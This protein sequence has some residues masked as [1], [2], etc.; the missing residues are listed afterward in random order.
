ME[1]MLHKMPPPLPPSQ[2]SCVRG[3]HLQ[4]QQQQQR[5]AAAELLYS[6]E[7]LSARE[8]N[9][10]K[11]K[12]KALSRVDSLRSHDSFGP[13][14]SLRSPVARSRSSHLGEQSSVT[15]GT[16]AGE[17][18][19]AGGAGEPASEGAAAAAGAGVGWGGGREAAIGS[20]DAEEEWKA[21]QAGAWPLQRVCDQLCVDILDPAW[22]VGGWAGGGVP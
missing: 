10:L 3:T 7:G 11:R 5:Q 8:R 15:G 4:Q 19:V 21:I 16:G 17:G 22:E 6:M 2:V 18:P 14:G 1:Q 12:A 20:E 9:K 13:R